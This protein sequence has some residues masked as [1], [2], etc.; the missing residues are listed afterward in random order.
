MVW[1]NVNKYRKNLRNNRPLRDGEGA[2]ILARQKV[3][4]RGVCAGDDYLTRLTKER[5]KKAP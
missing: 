3:V 2:Q 5:F 4:R 1:I